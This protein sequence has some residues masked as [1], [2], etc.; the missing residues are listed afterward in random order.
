MGTLGKHWKLT[1][2]SKKN[3]SISSMGKRG[4]NLGKHFSDKWKNRIR[5]SNIGKKHNVSREGLQRQKLAHIGRLGE[6]A[7]HFIHGLSRTKTYIAEKNKRWVAN[8]Y[9]KKLMHNKRRRIIKMGNGGSHTL[10][11]WET[12]KAQYNWTC[13]CCHKSEPN[14]LL[15]EDHIIPLSKG[16]SDNIEN[17]QPL[18]KSCNTKKYNKFK[19]WRLL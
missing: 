13:L 2:E 9:E 7:T 18:C 5:E 15:T 8:N 1:E 11:E 19:D 16:G 10:A 17:I 14:I 6:K 3:I 4:T 12:L